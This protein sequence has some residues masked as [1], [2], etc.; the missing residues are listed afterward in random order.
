MVSSYNPFENA[1]ARQALGYAINRKL[2]L[3][4]IYQGME[5]GRA[6]V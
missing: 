6:H 2:M 3:D 4:K 5:I 1:K